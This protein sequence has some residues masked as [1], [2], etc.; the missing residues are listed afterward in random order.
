[1]GKA[2][3]LLYQLLLIAQIQYTSEAAL[4]KYFIT[5]KC[6][7]DK[8][9]GVHYC[10]KGANQE[11][12]LDPRAE[13]ILFKRI[14]TAENQLKYGFRGRFKVSHAKQTTIMQFL[15]RDLSNDDMYKPVLF[16]VAWV[17][18]SGR[19]RVCMFE[20][21]EFVWKHVPRKFWVS[22]NASG[23]EVFLKVAGRK[24][25]RFN[26]TH[27]IRGDYRPKGAH[28]VRWGVYHH[29]VANARA[30]SRAEVRVTRIKLRGFDD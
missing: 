4:I 15:N 27:T 5:G 21:C 7:I 12:Q 25:Q 17:K 8:K 10:R 19:L 24:V 11:R 26:L 2:I 16:L 18:K 30:R 23:Q 13:T 6:G 1:M 22:F 20:T 28:D 14:P 29:D 9:S 3:F